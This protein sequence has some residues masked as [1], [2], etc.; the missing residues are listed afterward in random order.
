M[1]RASIVTFAA[2]VSVAPAAAESAYTRLDLDECE[3]LRVY[4]DGG[5][6]LRCPGYGGVE[7]FVSEGDARMEVDYGV[8]NEA[9][10]TFSAFNGV[11][12]TI[13]WMVGDDGI[14]AAALRFLIDVDGR[15]AQALVVSRIGDRDNPGCVV[16]V[17]DA[18]AEQANG[19][20]RGLGAM[21]P[22]FRCDTDQ[23]VIVPGAGP[24]VRGFN[25]ANR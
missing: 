1:L 19:I 15:S 24:L 9:F 17:V 10:E 18:A 14:Y 20:A 22:L 5:A 6:D 4:E 11:G 16:G 13:E 21:A 7:V 23:V 12:E 3:T 8:R 25:G 2:L